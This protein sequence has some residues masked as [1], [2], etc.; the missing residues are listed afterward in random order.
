MICDFGFYCPQGT[1]NPTGCPAGESIPFKSKQLVDSV[2]FG[3]V[4]SVPF[5]QARMVLGLIWSGLR[6]ACLVLSGSLARAVTLSKS[7]L[8]RCALLVS[9]AQLPL[10]RQRGILARLGL[11]PVPLV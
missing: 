3:M 7:I 2:D 9:I 10:L 4:I 5:V 1:I 8:P 6:N 11:G